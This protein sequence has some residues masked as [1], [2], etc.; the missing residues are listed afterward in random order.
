MS[1]RN[2]PR[3]VTLV[4]LLVALAVSTVVMVGVVAVARAQQQAY[5]D[6]ARLRAAQQSARNAALFIE[7]K[8][9]LAGYGMAPSLAFDFDRYTTGPCP[10][11]LDSGSGCARDRVNDSDELVWYARNPS[12]WVPHDPDASTTLEPAGR[13]W[14]VT[15]I[16]A[17]AD[18]LTVRARQGQ[19][20]RKGQVL[21]VVCQGGA[22]Y[23]YVTVST[24]V[25][26][27]TGGGA[28]Q[29]P[30]VPETAADPFQRQ[31]AA[32]DDCF[33]AGNVRAFQIDRYRLHVR[34]VDVGGG[35]K[36]PYLV[37]DQG[38]D[39]AGSTD[40]DAADEQLIAG[41]IESMQVAYVLANG[42]EVGASGAAGAIV[43][44]GGAPGD[45]T[46]NK[47]T[48]LQFPGAAPADPKVSI[49]TPT[50]W[51]RH[52]MGP[53]AAAE[54]LTNHQANIRAVRIALVARSPSPD[55]T[56]RTVPPILHFNQTSVASW[57]TANDGYQR[58]SIETTVPLPNMLVQGMPYF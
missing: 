18:T 16:S 40:V 21:E 9:P 14:K 29:I 22:H 2:D 46:A 54:R 11:E 39:V 30:L 19:S 24:S 57:I 35:L 47:L 31:D 13:A 8:L 34:P 7:Q 37:L 15:G 56:R 52:Y 4:E 1:A 10:A 25:D 28:V 45:S 38:I 41:G 5:H 55:L 32:T 27:P 26:A 53:P 48:T 20:F 42:T 43:L 3:G 44:A 51:F 36:D 58:V 50:S 12:Y 17:T 6:G 33:T 49:Y 23:V